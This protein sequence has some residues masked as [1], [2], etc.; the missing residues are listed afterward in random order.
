MSHIPSQFSAEQFGMSV[1]E[2]SPQ[3]KCY[4]KNTKGPDFMNTVYIAP[5]H[6]CVACNKSFLIW[7]NYI[8]THTHT[9]THACAHTHMRTRT[10]TYI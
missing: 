6:W 8:H 4:C 5:K 7:N 10:H 3:V 1:I 2:I 9:H